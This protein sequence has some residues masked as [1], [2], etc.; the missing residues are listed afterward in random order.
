MKRL[1]IG[2]LAALA[3]ALSVAP[4]AQACPCSEPP[5]VEGQTRWSEQSELTYTC[6]NGQWHE[7]PYG[8]HS[9]PQS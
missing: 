5:G 3:I 9:G 1:V 7:G 2:G 6:E 4:A 8:Y